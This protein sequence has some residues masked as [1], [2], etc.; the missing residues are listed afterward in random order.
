VPEIDSEYCLTLSVHHQA[1]HGY[2]EPSFTYTTL[3]ALMAADLRKPSNRNKVKV[4]VKV[5][6]KNIC[7]STCHKINVASIL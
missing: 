2:E 3:P 6:V 1:T 4:K 5:K 7:V